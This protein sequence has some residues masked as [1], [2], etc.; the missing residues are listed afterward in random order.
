MYFEQSN[1]RL[2]PYHTTKMG[3]LV[4]E[5]KY[6]QSSNEKAATLDNIHLKLY[7]NLYCKNYQRKG[8]QEGYSYNV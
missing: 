2:Q 4:S 8:V 6:E 5:V 3:M 1:I 7:Y